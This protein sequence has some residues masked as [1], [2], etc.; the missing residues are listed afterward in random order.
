MLLVNINRPRILAIAIPYL[1]V[2]SR[3]L[4]ATFSRGAYLGVALAGVVAGYVRGKMFVIGAAVAGLLL[5][6]AFPEVVPESLRARMGQTF[7]QSRRDA[8]RWTP[9]RRRASSCGTRRSR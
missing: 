9:A 8:K 7:V 6:I 1:I 4:L 3:I 5:V 2:T